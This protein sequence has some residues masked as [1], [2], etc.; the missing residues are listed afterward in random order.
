ATVTPVP[1]ST[2][3]L[4]TPITVGT[5]MYA[6]SVTADGATAYVANKAS[7]NVTP[8]SLATATA[9]S[10]ITVGTS[11]GPEDIAITPDQAPVAAFTATAAAVNAPS[12][13]DASASTVKFGTITS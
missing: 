4:G 12:S 10:P 8:I 9:L 5:N 13:F 1:L 7:Q 11:P 2:L 3:A 6:I